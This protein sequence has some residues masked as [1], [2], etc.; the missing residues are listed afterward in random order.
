VPLGPSAVPARSLLQIIRR[1]ALVLKCGQLRLWLALLE[2]T[3]RTP[4]HSVKIA[5]RP[6]AKMAAISEGAFPEAVKRLEREGLITVSRGD[7]HKRSTY[8]VRF[9]QQLGASI[10]DAP[11]LVG[12]SIS[13]APDLVGAS[14]SDAP[15][16]VGA[17][18][19][20]APDPPNAET[21][22][23]FPHDQDA[24][25]SRAPDYSSR[26]RASTESIDFDLNLDRVFEANYSDFDPATLKFFGNWLHSFMAKFGRSLVDDTRYLETKRGVP[27]PDKQIVARF[28]AVAEPN[29]LAAML[30]NLTL[31]AK[32]EDARLNP[33]GP[34]SDSGPG[35]LQPRKYSWFLTVALKRIHNIHHTKTHD[36][37]KEFRIRKRSGVRIPTAANTPPAAEQS[38]LEFAEEIK[39][40]AKAKGMK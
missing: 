9:W 20:D 35:T 12:A 5:L 7:R 37:E 10:S 3:E 21:Q 17:S 2:L 1:V 15:D 8:T 22:E 27:P 36:A 26:A 25:V 29:R 16:L 38:G 23:L 4:N 14:I 32:A 31:E 6:L 11:D 13:D 30:E 40:L 28:C 18:I 19:S 24:S 39:Q 33:R 34:G